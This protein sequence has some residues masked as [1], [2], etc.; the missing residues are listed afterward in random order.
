MAS[1]LFGFPPI[2]FDAGLIVMLPIIFSVAKQFGGSVPAC[3]ASAGA[4]AVMHAFLPPHLGPVAASELLG[5]NIGLLTV[6]GLLVAL[7]TWYLGAYLFGLWSG[8][9]FELPLPPSFTASAERS[10]TRRRASAR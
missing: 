8:K 7:P 4:F 2:F 9:K 6:V 3:P 10:P 5:A 1:P